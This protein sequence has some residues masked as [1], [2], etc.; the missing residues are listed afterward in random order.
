MEDIPLNQKELIK[1]GNQFH[2]EDIEFF[3]IAHNGNKVFPE[4]SY[5]IISFRRMNKNKQNKIK[6]ELIKAFNQFGDKYNHPIDYITT[7]GDNTEGIA[8][9]VNIFYNQTKY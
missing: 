8:I 5:C 4:A 2:N 1:I 7:E 9:D 6:K 3:G